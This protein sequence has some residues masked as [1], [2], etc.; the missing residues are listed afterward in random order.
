MTFTYAGTLA[1]E[2]DEIRFKIADTVSGSGV[3]PSGGNFTDEEISGLLSKEGSVGR[4]VAAIFENLAGIYANYVDSKIGPRD[5][6]LSQRAASYRALAKQW[7]E[8]YGFGSVTL[9]TGFVTRVD[10][11]SQDID[12][13]TV[14]DESA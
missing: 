12:S 11:Y 1:T 8:Q 5:E 2:L 6:K 7:R 3:K 14:A 9:A 13:G 10:G 4:T